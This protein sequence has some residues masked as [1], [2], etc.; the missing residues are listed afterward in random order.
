MKF[1][2][3]LLLLPF[4]ASAE[5]LVTDSIEAGGVTRTY[6]YYAPPGAPG[7]LPLVFVLHGAGGTAERLAPVV[8]FEK[9]PA[10]KGVLVVYPDGFEKHWNDL[11]GIPEWTAHQ[12]NIDDVG[13]IS[14]LIDRFVARHH[15]DPKRV[16]VTGVSNG[17]LMSHRLGCELAGKIAAIA[18]VVRTFTTKLAEGCRPARPI[19]VHMFFGTADKLVPFEGG[20]Q[21]MGS[22]ET[23]V[24]SA[25]Q[26]I[27][28]WAA[29]N[30]CSKPA[31]VTKTTEP[32]GSRQVF[33]SCRE[34]AEV[35]AYIRDGA[36][37]SWPPDANELIW[38]FFEKHPMR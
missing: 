6:R 14:A 33:S 9:L 15:A 32:A 7:K 25:Q 13:F 35:V 17:G 4:L 26:T 28:R 34:G 20:M 22:V 5:D 30:G 10:A 24:L 21:K 38:A 27:D 2:V 23:P 18:P 8:H 16:F 3:F 12:R 11:R 36:G 29:L 31:A 37:H 19:S 1:P